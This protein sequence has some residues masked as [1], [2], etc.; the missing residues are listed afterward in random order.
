M[1]NEKIKEGILY[2]LEGVS[3]T[4]D[5]HGYTFLEIKL[6]FKFNNIL[7]FCEETKES[8]KKLKNLLINMEKANL[9]EERYFGKKFNGR[10]DFSIEPLGTKLIGG[11]TKFLEKNWK[12]PEYDSLIY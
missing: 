1:D 2:L 12:I 5:G 3:P 8:W 4:G 7:N 6:F 10:V 9:I 11:K